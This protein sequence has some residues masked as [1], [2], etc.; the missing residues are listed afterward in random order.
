MY[1]YVRT[2][3]VHC[4][5]RIRNVSRSD[6]G[7]CTD[8][9]PILSRCCTEI[10]PILYRYCT[11]IVPIL[12]RNCTDIVQILYRNCTK[13]YRYCTEIVPIL[14]RNCT[15]NIPILY[16]YC[17]DICWEG[18]KGNAYL[19]NRR[20]QLI[21]GPRFKPQNSR[22]LGRNMTIRRL[23]TNSVVTSSGRR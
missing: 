6:I 2:L 16:R 7:Y 13:L 20:Q 9:V 15:D 1:I 19:R 23:A 22:S 21:A 10:V 5:Q 8:I 18:P 14:Y 4:V 17:S 3:I 12:Y 11:E